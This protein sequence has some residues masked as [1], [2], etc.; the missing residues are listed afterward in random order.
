VIARWTSVDPYAE[1]SRRFSPYN[2]GDDNSIRNIDLDG[3]STVNYGPLGP[4]G[5]N[6]G[7][8]SSPIYA[9]GDLNAAA[10]DASST[11]STGGLVVVA[12]GYATTFAGAP[13]VGLPMIDYGESSMAVGAGMS[14]V[15][16]FSQGHYASAAT[17]VTTSVAF[18]AAGK[19]L[20][21]LNKAGELTTTG[22]NVLGA[23]NTAAGKVTDMLVDQVKANNTATTSNSTTTTSSST[24]T[25]SRTT[26][27][28][29]QATIPLVPAPQPPPP[30]MLPNHG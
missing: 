27:T 19:E 25:S 15:N 29:S 16:D 17:T 14:V 24:K 30:V 5:G 23:V 4:G 26:T 12:A 13:E 3:D 20:N 21:T 8:P 7:V 1:K 22:K 6:L 9:G 10:D 28:S 11:L 18:G 2:Y